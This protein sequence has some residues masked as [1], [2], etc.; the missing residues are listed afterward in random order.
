MIRGAEPSGPVHD[1]CKQ[2]GPPGLAGLVRYGGDV[3][4]LVEDLEGVEPLTVL[5]LLAPLNNTT[6]RQSEF[7]AAI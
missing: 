3:D 5:S 7:L 6:S 1:L 4:Q 2:K